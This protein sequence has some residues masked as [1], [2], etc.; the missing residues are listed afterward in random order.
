MEQAIG[1]IIL[2][3]LLAGCLLVVRPFFSALLWGT[4]LT[5]SSWPL[6][7]RLVSLLKGR[8][9]LAAGLMG[10]GM[11]CVILV[12]FVIIGA[13]LGENVEELTAALRS[14][15]DAGPPGPPEWLAKIPL[16]GQQA[17]EYW[18]ALAADSSKLL[19]IGKRILETISGALVV[20]GLGL[21][22]GLVEL[23]LS[24]L[25]AFFLFP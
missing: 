9:T 23:A 7:R 25:V 5:V 6:Y 3:L 22:R 14:W 19:A 2:A 15:M 17:T 1:W 13:T 24:I 11:I 20:I 10:L 18:Q 16:V 8:R 12:P 4:V 21:G